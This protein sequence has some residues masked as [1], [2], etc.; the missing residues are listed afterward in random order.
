M[1]TSIACQNSPTPEKAPFSSC[2]SRTTFCASGAAALMLQLFLL[3]INLLPELLH[4][5]SHLG[6]LFVRIGARI[7]VPAT[8]GLVAKAT[9]F[10]HRPHRVLP[11]TTLLP[12]CIATRRTSRCRE[13]LGHEQT[14]LAWRGDAADGSNSLQTLATPSGTF[15]RQF[16]DSRLACEPD[17]RGSVLGARIACGF[18]ATPW[19]R[20][21]PTP[22]PIARL[23]TCFPRSARGARALGGLPGCW[24]AHR[25]GR[26]ADAS[27]I[28]PESAH[29][30]CLRATLV[31]AACSTQV[32]LESGDTGGRA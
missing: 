13:S 21:S 16:F 24:A 27:R 3:R 8:N 18:A 12:R 25:L 17:E 14:E 15:P 19:P 20:R 28:V 5:S 10:D 30:G 29:N 22:D 4:E 31:C 1:F 2:C 26:V 9:H 11:E 6:E 7:C 32:A 23:G